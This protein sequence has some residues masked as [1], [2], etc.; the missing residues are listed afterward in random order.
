MSTAVVTVHDIQ[1][2]GREEGLGL[3][4]TIWRPQRMAEH[5]M[6]RHFSCPSVASFATTAPGLPPQSTVRQGDVEQ[7]HTDSSGPL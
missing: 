7:F 1:V 6:T 5:D 4:W 2:R 3:L